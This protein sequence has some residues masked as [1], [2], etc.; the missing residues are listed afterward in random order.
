MRIGFSIVFLLV[1]IILAV[2]AAVAFRLKKSA[3]KKV[4]IL[5]LALIPPVIG[6]LI[7]VASGDRMIS[8]IGCY[9]YFLGM[10]FVM[11]ALATFAI[12]Y[13]GIKRRLRKVNYALFIPI[14]ID[15]VQFVMN[16]F[17]GNAF[18]ITPV[19]VEGYNYYKLVPYLGQTYH[20]ILDYAIF[21]AVLIAFIVKTKNTP[22]IY[23]ERY[24]VIFITMVAVGAWQTFYIFSGSPIDCSMVGY[25]VFGLLIFYF[26]CFYRPRRLLDSM[27]ADL[28]SAMQDAVFLFDASDECI[29]A[30]DPGTELLGIKND[31]YKS[32][33]Y[34]LPVMFGALSNVGNWTLE[35]KVFGDDGNIRYYTLERHAVGKNGS[36][37]VIHDTTEE[38]QEMQQK[39]YN[40]S[41]D[42]LTGLFT[43]EH[44]YEQIREELDAHPEVTHDVVFLDVDDFKLANDIFGTDF[45]DQVLMAI[46]DWIRSVFGDQGIYGRLF[47]D[48]FGICI[49]AD[50][51]DRSLVEKELSGFV[52][53][54]GPIKYALSIRIGVYRVTDQ[55][56]EVSVMFDR[57]HMAL[58]TIKDNVHVH[59]AFY[60][61]EIRR[62]ALWERNIS[63]EVQ[64][65]IDN[66]EICPY[67]QALVDR[68]GRIVGAEALVRWN[69][70]Q[71]GFLIPG[72]FLP[73]LEKN[74]LIAQVDKYMWRSACEILSRWDNDLFIS[75]NISPKDFYYMNI[76]DELKSIVEEFGIDPARL[77]LEITETV[78][79]SDI[80]NRL[81][82][83][84]EL[85]EYG[86]IIEMDDFGSGYSSLSLLKDMPVD[87]L[88][89]D[90]EFLR[91]SGVNKRTL[92]IM[93]SIIKMSE[94]L[95][96]DSLT[97]GVETE[98][99]YKTLSEMGCKMFQGYYFTKPMPVADFEKKW[100]A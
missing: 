29:W 85:R 34:R 60:D 70:P 50:S 31:E 19:A 33:L 59:I 98:K 92:T 24:S 10:D 99:Q 51:V 48:K 74:G 90:M 52:V 41:H 73:V 14:L 3:A 88:K 42:M 22:R 35:K 69:H 84:N 83:L 61:E 9:I 18:S 49:P 68:E 16:P 96:M 79:M 39:I 86:F 66:K 5:L 36:F 65:A 67:L 64:N 53:E 58:Y 94:E 44:L 37:L 81:R 80:E 17:F 57:A 40:A 26:T 89:I 45:G 95:G 82:I 78:M 23:S 100:V 27:L 2:C 54:K 6:N 21:F 93:H 76:A 28:I 46:A 7:I 77:R 30:N 75:V 91:E 12:E 97:E 8:L 55:D 32:A 43:R 25:G 56:L 63:V 20:R 72:L 1:A 47:G 11:L 15:I 71:K 4:A 87:V 62:K 13:C 38:K